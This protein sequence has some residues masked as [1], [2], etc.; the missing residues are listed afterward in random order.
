MVDAAFV[1]FLVLVSLLYSF[2]PTHL[3]ARKHTSNHTMRIIPASTD[4]VLGI[5]TVS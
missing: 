2:D 4:E 1:E 3:D 5:G